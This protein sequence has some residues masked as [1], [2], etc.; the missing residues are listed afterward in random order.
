MNAAWMLLLRAQAL[1]CCRERLQ[2]RALSAPFVLTQQARIGGN[3]LVATP[4][5]ATAS[6]RCSNVQI[7]TAVHCA[8]WNLMSA[9]DAQLGVQGHAS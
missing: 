9:H 4:F 6:A 1:P 8:G 5:T 7:S 2:T 3:F